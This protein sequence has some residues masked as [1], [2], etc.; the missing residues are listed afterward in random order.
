MAGEPSSIEEALE[1]ND[2]QTDVVPSSQ[3]EDVSEASRGQI[4]NCLNGLIGLNQPK[5]C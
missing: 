3:Q 4:D 2:A 5:P 1:S